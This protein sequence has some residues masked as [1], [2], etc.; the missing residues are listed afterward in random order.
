M[1]KEDQEALWTRGKEMAGVKLSAS[2]AWRD[3]SRE[4]TSPPP[5][6]HTVDLH[7]TLFGG[8]FETDQ[9]LW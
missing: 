7:H 9:C 6:H 4:G 3:T 8:S 5:R 1:M 2:L